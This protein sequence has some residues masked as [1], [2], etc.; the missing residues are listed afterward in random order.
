MHKE[1]EGRL[2]TV[3]PGSSYSTAEV[4]PL[5]TRESVRA[6]IISLVTNDSLEIDGFVVIGGASMVLHGAKE[7]TGDIDVLVDTATLENLKLTEGSEVRLPPQRAIDEGADN[8]SVWIPEDVGAGIHVPVSATDA[9]GDGH[10]PL[11]Y[12]QLESSQVTDIDVY[13]MQI[14][15]LSLHV[16]RASKMA[17]GRS[18]DLRDIKKIDEFLRS[19]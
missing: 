9:L 15:C 16:V 5:R 11:I 2:R 7:F 18:Q 13:G 17:L 4:L 14:S 12:D 3:V 19:S 6:T 8:Y 10:Y 1:S